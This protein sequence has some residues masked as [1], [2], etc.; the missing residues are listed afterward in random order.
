MATEKK[1][2]LRFPLFQ[3]LLP[4][5]FVW[6]GFTENY[7]V[8]PV[9][10]SFLLFLFYLGVASVLLFIFWLIYR[11]FRKAALASFF[12]LCIQF[13]FG[14]IHDLLK[15]IAADSFLTRYSFIIPFVLVILLIAFILLKRS[16]RN[17][18]RT[19]YY[20]N[21]LLIV[22]LLVDTVLFLASKKKVESKLAVQETRLISCD[23]CQKPDIYLIIADAYPGRQ[24]LNDLFNYD[25]SGFEDALRQRGFHIVDST[26]SNYNFT[27]F[28]LASMLN[29]QFLPGIYGS[30]SNKN[31]LS[32]C[33]NTIRKNAF[34]QYLQSSGYKFYNYSI[35]DFEG[36]PAVTLPTFLPLKT[37]PITSQ[38]FTN[39]LMRDLGYHLATTFKLPSM[40][41]KV[42]YS[43]LR[44]NEKIIRLT[45]K[46]ITEVPAN[47]KFV[48]THLM[49]P[50]HPFYYDST[51]KPLPM[52]FLEDG[53]YYNK[54]LRISYLKYSNGEF[55]K[56]IDKILKG[57]KS[58]PIILFMGDHGYR[59][60]R[61]KVD[62]KYF[63]MNLNAILI[64]NGDYSRFYSGMSNINQLRVLL[65]TQF[66][67]HLAML[68]DSTIAITE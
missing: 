26:H 60:F 15:K 17:F 55:L 53:H 24:E 12:V 62:P 38:T 48:Y 51:G 33:M 46:V 58:P 47:P 54:E 35:F 64:P 18:Y 30:N 65:N 44:N 61:E 28:S 36:Q 29:M 42:K 3:W 14:G 45:E 41:R 67:Q 39:R 27:A 20:L 6:H 13:F 25:N 59:E 16:K 19:V 21:T 50:H 9:K 66:N 63:Y 43:D 31:D 4:L 7:P 5:F 32:I 11:N 49:M 56:L 57:N 37:K 8:I 23:T 52:E 68:K 40:I 22:L 2:M 10:D 34:L 1:N